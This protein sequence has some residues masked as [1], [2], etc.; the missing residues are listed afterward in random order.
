M[1]EMNKTVQNLE[2]DLEA[3]SGNSNWENPGDGN[4]V[5]ENRSYR[6]KHQQQNT[7]EG[8]LG[9]NNHRC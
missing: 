7:R 1:K 5:E 8:R 4:A 3:I 6:Q 9:R 2:I